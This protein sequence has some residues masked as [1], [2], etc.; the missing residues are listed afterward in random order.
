MTRLS[1]SQSRTK[2]ELE[3]RVDLEQFRTALETLMGKQSQ[4]V[5]TLVRYVEAAQYTLE[6]DDFIAGQDVTLWAALELF[7]DVVQCQADMQKD[8]KLSKEQHEYIADHI[9]KGINDTQVMDLLI[10]H[11]SDSEIRDIVKTMTKKEN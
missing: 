8:P 11:L 4:L 9:G 3:E 6:T 10:E 5:D 2:Y 1:T 7:V